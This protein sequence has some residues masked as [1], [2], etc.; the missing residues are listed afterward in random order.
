MGEG[1]IVYV[2][3]LSVSG[4]TPVSIGQS[5][6]KRG[7]INN[8]MGIIAYP[9]ALFSVDATGTG[10]KNYGADNAYWV[11][12]K[13]SIDTDVTG[14]GCTRYGRVVGNKVT[15]TTA[16]GSS[17]AIDGGYDF[18]WDAISA[19]KVLG[20]YVHD[21]GDSTTTN[22][23][24][25]TY[26]RI[27]WDV[28]NVPGIEIAWNRLE[29]NKARFGIHYY[30]QSFI[31]SGDSVY[32]APGS[33]NSPCY[34]YSNFVR[35]QGGAGINIGGSGFI[36]GLNKMTGTW[37]VYNNVLVNAGL[38]TNQG[39]SCFPY[40]I[41][42]YG[43]MNDFDIYLYNNTIHGY[44]DSAETG[45]VVIYAPLSD[46]TADFAGTWHWQNNIVVDT[47]DFAQYTTSNL[48]T[49]STASN[50]IWYNGG[51]SAPAAAPTW[52]TSPI[53]EDPLFV[54]MASGDY[55][56]Q[57]LSPAVGAGV[58]LNSFFTGDYHSINRGVD[59]WDIGAFE[60]AEGEAVPTPTPTPTP[61]THR[62]MG[63]KPGLLP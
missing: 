41:A 58:I 54:N 4:S 21:F 33:F 14:I 37:Y 53:I 34:V 17:G 47:K 10:V 40:A 8:M 51:D 52:D 24:H 30:D 15:G 55:N 60:Y 57:S 12:S 36:D 44:G 6:R 22:Q 25:T 16:D 23:H 56:L 20:N 32:S 27:R 13:L 28:S 31:K 19:V 3:D 63:A 62:S 39:I 18:G 26:F 7:T 5:A 38:T 50:N 42:F 9:G 2:C 43:E 46:G 45:S 11:V 59:A 1:D 49:P 48:V 61:A 35:N 29:D